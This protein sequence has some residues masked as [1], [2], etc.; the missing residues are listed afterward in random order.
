MHF[1]QKNIKEGNLVKL[2]SSKTI[3]NLEVNQDLKFIIPILFVNI[4]IFFLS[5]RFELERI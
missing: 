3:E 1:F 4:N 2:E 5:K